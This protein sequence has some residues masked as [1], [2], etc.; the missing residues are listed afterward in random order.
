MSFYKTYNPVSGSVLNEY[1]YATGAEVSRSLDLLHNGFQHWRQLS[2]TERQKALG[3]AVGLFRQHKEELAKLMTDEMGKPYFQSI[4]EIDK[5]LASMEYMCTSHYPQQNITKVQTE[6]ENHT[7]NHQIYHKPKGII[8]GVMPW[9]Y[10]LWQAVR[11]VFPALLSGNTVLLKHSEISPSTGNFMKKMFN[12]IEVKNI[13]EHLI[14]AHTLTESVIADAR[15]HGVSLTGSIKAGLT[16]SG[17]AGKYMK[18]G[19]FELGGSDAYL[20]LD[21]ANIEKSAATIAKSRLQNTGQSCIAAKRCL[22]SKTKS[23]EFF[24]HLILNFEKYK[25]GNIFERSTT[26]GPLASSRFK[27]DDENHLKFALKYCD[28]VYE[29][30]ADPGLIKSFAKDSDK[31]AFV[32]IRI[33]KVRN[34]TPEFLNYVKTNEFFSPTLLVF[35]Y[36]SLEQAL[37][38]VNGTD[39]GLGAA[40]F[41]ENIEQAHQVALKIDSGMVSINEMVQSNVALPF[42]GVK[43]SGIGREMGTY[44]FEEFTDVQVITINRFPQVEKNN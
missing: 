2:F 13:F 14:F 6:V 7:L 23:Q 38:L 11:M 27:V 30:A 1:E 3:P 25:F 31:Q 32:P 37:Q 16:L 43:S 44:G 21:E 15:V 20:V 10:P 29:K 28:L 5:C 18:R 26:L 41:S 17:Y 34:L 42:G 4:A 19:V 12:Q 9:N 35:E 36:T 8:L 33:L 40:V 22:I 24:D 39:F